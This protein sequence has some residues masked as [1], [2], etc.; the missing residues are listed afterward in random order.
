MTAKTKVLVEKP[1]G[2]M[3]PAIPVT[4]KARIPVKKPTGKPT[5]KSTGRMEHQSSGEGNG[6]NEDVHLLFSKSKSIGRRN[7]TDQSDS[8]QEDSVQVRKTRRKE[9]AP[10][11]TAPSTTQATQKTAKTNRAQVDN[12]EPK[13]S[14]RTTKLTYKVNYMQRQ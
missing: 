6:G 11:S 7:Q 9:P 13:R 5:G 8:E 14:A 1:T 3:E 2:R 10:K 4:A 12:P